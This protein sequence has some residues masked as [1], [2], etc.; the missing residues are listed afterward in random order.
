[1]AA[2]VDCLDQHSRACV[3][4][5]MTRAWCL[6]PSRAGI[7]PARVVRR[8]GM[9][10]TLARA[11]CMDGLVRLLAHALVG[12][13]PVRGWTRKPY[14]GTSQ[15]ARRWWRYAWRRCVLHH[16]VVLTGWSAGAGWRLAGCFHKGGRVSVARPAR[17]SISGV[18]GSTRYT[19][20]STFAPCLPNVLS[21]ASPIWSRDLSAPCSGRWLGLRLARGQR[22]SPQSCAG[23]SATMG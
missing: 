14:P 3:S 9:R 5:R 17:A 21:L 6:Q 2:L 16:V 4:Q 12:A 20:P 13:A 19:P 1:M 11:V 7:S 10:R 23:S 15:Y 18:G 22:F 8:K